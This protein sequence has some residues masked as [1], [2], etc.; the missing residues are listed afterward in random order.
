M[1]SSFAQT[2]TMNQAY[3]RQINN[4]ST[5]PVNYKQHTSKLGIHDHEEVKE[6]SNESSSDDI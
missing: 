4:S 2:Q 3:M 6:T 1:Q 5:T